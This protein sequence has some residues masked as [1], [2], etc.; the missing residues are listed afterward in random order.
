MR[1][2]QQGVYSENTMEKA[3][4]V[5]LIKINDCDGERLLWNSHEL[6][7]ISWAERGP[8][9]QRAGEVADLQWESYD[10][11]QTLEEVFVVFCSYFCGDS[12]FIA[13]VILLFSLIT[14]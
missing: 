9:K 5:F 4:G 13:F 2:D 6:S 8:S 1:C 7:S 3:A 12:A 14:D 10:L 11:F